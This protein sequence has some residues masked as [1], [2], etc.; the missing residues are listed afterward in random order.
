MP[1]ASKDNPQLYRH[2]SIPES[3]L[4]DT[5][6]EG[7]RGSSD[8]VGTAEPDPSCGVYDRGSAWPAL[9]LQ[10][11]RAAH[12]YSKY[13]QGVTFKPCP[14]E[15]DKYDALVPRP[16]N[17]EMPQRVHPCPRL[18]DDPQFPR[19]NYLKLQTPRPDAHRL[20]RIFPAEPLPSDSP[21]KDA[22]DC[23]A[24]VPSIDEIRSQAGSSGRDLLRFL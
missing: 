24:L 22:Q 8:G 5:L 12:P 15:Q 18:K 19:Q 7:G 1:G 11:Y 16:Q 17:S 10:Q 21:G 3:G 9:E 23:F 6:A 20:V 14:I 2:Y 13:E 4:R